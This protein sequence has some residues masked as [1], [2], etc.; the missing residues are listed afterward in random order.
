MKAP[1]T[2]RRF[3]IEVATTTLAR[4][5]NDAHMEAITKSVPGVAHVNRDI[6]VNALSTALDWARLE[7][8]AA[9]VAAAQEAVLSATPEPY[10]P[11]NQALSLIQTAFDEYHKSKK[12]SGQDMVEVPFDP[13]DPGWLTIAFEKLK[14]LTRGKRTFIKHTSTASFRQAL[15]ENAV[16]ALFGDWGTGEPT[17]QRVMDQIKLKQPTHAI[18]LGDVSYSG[19]PYED[20]KHFLDIIDRHGPSQPPCKYFSLNG[21][22]DMYS[23]GYGYFDSILPA[24]G[25]EASYFN[26]QNQHWQLIGVDSSYEDYGLQD[27]QHE[28]LS[29]QLD[30]QGPKSILMSH[31][32]LFSPYESRATDRTLFKKTQNLLLKI[33]AWFW[34]HEHKCIILGNR[35][36]IKPRCI[37][38]GAMPSSLPYG[39]PS[40]PVDKVDERP[41]PDGAALHGFAL[42]RF[43][44]ARIDVSYIDEFGQQFFAEQ[45]S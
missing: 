29:A 4:L 26:L 11:S 6:V 28:W 9:P 5:H 45:F 38:H 32:Q 33:H 22:H 24:F 21:N 15:P 43:A 12:E 34:G 18:H 39:A 17:A 7:R 25:Q 13:H 1:I 41:G 27:P 16:V 10:I 3:L 2:N 23:G 8:E 14:A 19:T 44:G 36:G 35:L 31:H 37:G 30:A 40:I 20:K 42:L